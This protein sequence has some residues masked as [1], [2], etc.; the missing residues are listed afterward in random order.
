MTWDDGSPTVGRV[1]SPGSRRSSAR[2]AT[3]GEELSTRHI[4]VAAA[5]Q[6]R[7]EELVLHLAA[8]LAASTGLAQPLPRGRRRAER[9]RERP[10]PAGDAVRRAL[11]PAGGRRLGTAVGAAFHVWHEML[12]RPR[13]LRHAPRLHRA[14]A[15]TTTS[16]EAALAGSRARR[17]SGSTTTRSS[18]SVAE[19]LA[20]GDVVG[21]FQG[22]MEFGPRAL[23]NRS[24][25]ADPRRADMKDVLNAR[26][27]H[28]EPF[29]PFAPSVLAERDR[30]TGSTRATRRRSWC[31]STTCCPRS[32]SSCRRSP[33]STAPGACR[34]SRRPTNPRY[35]RLI[36]EFERQ[37]GV[38]ILLNTSFN[39]SEPIVMTP[40]RRARD[41]REDAH[42]PARARE[43]RR[44]AR[45]LGVQREQRLGRRGPGVALLGA[46]TGVRAELGAKRARR[47][48]AA[49]ARRGAPR[50]RAAGTSRPVTPSSTASREPADRGRD[51]RAPVGHRL[52]RDHAVAL[53]ARRDAD[54]RGPLV[55]AR[56]ARPAATKPTASGTRSRSGPS[57]T[58]TRGRPSVASRKLEDPLLLAQPAG[59]EHVRRL[60]GL[61][62]PRPGSRRRSGSRATSRAPSSRRRLGEERRRGDDDARAAE[63]GRTSHGARRA[64]S[65]SV[66]H[67]WSDERL[68]VASAASADGIQ[69][70]CTT[71][72]SRPPGGRRARSRR[73]TAGA[74]ATSHGSRRRFWT[75]PSP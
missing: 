29:R 26:I 51:D 19:R 63:S 10:H 4:D 69:W 68:P 21:W 16:V 15:T 24:I 25:L 2:R 72:A 52:A 8:S 67:T 43:L 11:R 36:A 9:G 6:A 70:A 23:G 46:A 75:I 27:K 38:P 14:G 13:G 58:I 56:R 57:P 17:A 20:A 41:V 54:D 5:L 31:S 66:P 74:R 32:A 44:A 18:R 59:E 40:A 64:S 47:R 62:R 53:A 28:R 61:G 22:R 73:G 71:S 35:Y 34:R 45:R 3:P 55:V 48:A 42:R 65:T 1:F 12:G 33:T 37:T 50:R 30:A 49:R 39:E 7:L 60:V